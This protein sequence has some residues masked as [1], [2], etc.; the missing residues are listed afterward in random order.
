VKIEPLGDRA[1]RWEIAPE[2]DRAALSRA[3]RDAPGVLDAVVTERFACVVARPR[4]R[5]DPEALARL[6]V[7][8]LAETNAREHVIRVR[9]DGADLA[10]LAARARISVDELAR[11]H[12]ATL[13]TVALV[14][15]LPGFAYLRGLD[16]SIAAPRRMSP[17]PRVPAGA[18]GIAGEYTGV[19]PFASPGGWNLIGTAL[20]F[21]AFDATRGSTLA[22]GDRVRFE[23]SP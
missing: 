17:R 21:T 4:A 10:E 20:D 18:V 1:W 19:Y 8:P 13:Y 23:R 2:V 3:L 12:T 16:A 15:F 14:G 6:A 11:R 5:V 22:L 9:Y 7:A